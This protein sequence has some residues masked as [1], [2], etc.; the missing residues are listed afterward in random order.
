MLTKLTPKPTLKMFQIVLVHISN[1][2]QTFN[3]G[4]LETYL[5]LLVLILKL[6]H[7]FECIS[8]EL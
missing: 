6:Q 2:S 4:K 7:S 1:V 3:G 5:H 8:E